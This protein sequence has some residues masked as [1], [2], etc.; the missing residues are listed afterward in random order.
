MSDFKFNISVGTINIQLE[1]D[2][3]LVQ[4][5]LQDLRENGLGKLSEIPQT[6][7]SNS[8]AVIEPSTNIP[9]ANPLDFTSASATTALFPSL[10]DVALKNLPS[11]EWEWVLLY[12]FYASDYG[13]KSVARDDI[14]EMYNKTNRMTPSRNSNFFNNLSRLV[15]NNFVSAL[16]DD[17]YI[18][19]EDGKKKVTEILSNKAKTE[20]KPAKTS[21]KK[22][23]QYQ[24]IKDLDLSPT[25]QRKGLKEFVTELNPK[26][27]INISTTI[28]YYLQNIFGHESIDIDVV[29]TCWRELG[30]K[31]P[32]DL[33][34]NLRDICSSRYGY[35]N[36]ENGIYSI[37]TRGINLV[38]HT[39]K[40][41]NSK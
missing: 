40:E 7:I 1:G 5:I 26:S 27:N 32:D 17:E 38:E 21:S 12:T 18:V 4:S 41:G 36:V 30:S 34:G 37:S 31:I 16:N 24:L 3:T 13:T 35:A 15:T 14:K 33:A 19:C 2:G 22:S 28:I 8:S 23:K 11:N 29:F 39:L 9:T 20:S 25:E 6:H 10:K